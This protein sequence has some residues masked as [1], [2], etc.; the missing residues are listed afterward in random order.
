MEHVKIGNVA[1][2][3]SLLW[4]LGTITTFGWQG[5]WATNNRVEVIALWGALSF[6]RWLDLDSITINGDAKSIID[7]IKNFTQFHL[8]ILSI[9][10]ARIRELAASFRSINY[11]HIF[12]EQ[13]QLADL[14]SKRGIG[15]IPGKYFFA[16]YYQNSLLS[17]GSIDSV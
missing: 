8:S 16:V 15:V 3:W 5:G 2:G 4:S 1:V 17:V 7:W 10:M 14:L 6:A 12:K 13:N 9:W 11:N